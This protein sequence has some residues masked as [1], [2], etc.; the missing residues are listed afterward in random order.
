MLTDFSHDF[1]RYISCGVPFAQHGALAALQGP[2][3]ATDTMLEAY[4]RRRDVALAILK[5]NG[6][7]EYVQTA[8]HPTKPNST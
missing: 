2:R 1:C 7:Y 5:E 8:E 4:K 3:E 6:L